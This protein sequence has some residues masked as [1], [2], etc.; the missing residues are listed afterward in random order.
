M[1]VGLN[2]NMLLSISNAFGF[3]FGPAILI[4][5]IVATVIKND[6][7]YLSGM[8]F[9]QLFSIRRLPFSGIHTQCTLM[10]LFQ[11]CL[12]HNY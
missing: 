8:V 6:Q 12:Q 7:P 3:T 9:Q 1:V 2:L 4:T 5:A 11:K 10:F